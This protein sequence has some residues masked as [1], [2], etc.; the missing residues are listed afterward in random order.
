L[1]II[2]IGEVKNL[3]LLT[4][5]KQIK[6][7]HHYKNL[8]KTMSKYFIKNQSKS[9]F[10]IY[11]KYIVELFNYYTQEKNKKITDESK[12]TPMITIETI[13]TRTDLIEFVKNFNQ[14]NK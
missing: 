4:N 9:S 7:S 8:K 10:T 1:E 5:N 12:K 13:P 2:K 6:W 14:N 3:P 11:R